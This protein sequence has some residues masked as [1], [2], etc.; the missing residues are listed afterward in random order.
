[1]ST[2]QPEVLVQFHPERYFPDDNEMRTNLLRASSRELDGIW[3][4]IDG[5]IGDSDYFLGEDYSIVDM[6][7]VMQALWTENQ[8][9]N[10][11][12]CSNAVR[13]MEN[14]FARPAV[15]RTLD[16]HGVTELADISGG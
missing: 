9:S 8:P 13:V 15:R 5:Q 1:M 3:R 12:A 4:I 11:L 2:L 16:I 14:V 6:L 7:F 10:L